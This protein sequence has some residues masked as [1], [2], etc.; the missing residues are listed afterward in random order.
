MQT[1]QNFTGIDVSKAH[2]DIVRLE[3][4]QVVQHLHIPNTPAAL[5]EWLAQTDKE[6]TLFC[7]EATGQ[8]GNFLIAALTEAG[9]DVWV[10]N[11]LQIKRSMGLVRG[12]NDRVDAER[13]ARYACRF[14]DKVRLYQPP[15]PQIVRLRTLFHLREKLV[16]QRQQLQTCLQEAA[17]FQSREAYRLMQQHT[18]PLCRQCSKSIEKIEQQIQEL[19]QEDEELRESFRLATS[20]TG[21]GKVTATL[22]LILTDGFTKFD[23]A[24]Q[25]ACYAGV[26]PFAHASGNYKGRNRVS[27]LAH[28]PLKTAL[29]LCALSASRVEGEL[30]EYYCRKVAE[31][32][33]KMSVLN[34]LRNKILQRIFACVKNRTPYDRNGLNFNRNPLIMT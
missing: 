4:H 21:V 26:A 32:K 25:L 8:Y 27:H 23:N 33:N 13:I 3:N 12:K 16:K 17:P 1:Y 29:H 20:V 11:A 24:K 22:L 18:R 28:K 5:A 7:L 2:L 31:G 15:K 34:A 19:I 10:E 6:Q 9:A 14:Q 30:R